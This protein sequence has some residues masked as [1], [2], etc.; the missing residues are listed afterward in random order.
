MIKI[1]AQRPRRQFPK[2]FQNKKG[3]ALLMAIVLTSTLLLITYALSNITLKAL[4]LSYAGKNSE[5]AFYAADTGVECAQYWDI[6]NGE[7]NQGA[8]YTTPNTTIICNGN[9][10]V[11]NGTTRSEVNTVPEP[12][13]ASFGTQTTPAP[14][15]IVSLFQFCVN[16]PCTT[17]ANKFGPCAI[18]TVTK[19]TNPSTG[20]ITTSIE[21]R[22]YN[23]CNTDSVQRFE[24][25]LYVTY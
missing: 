23:T 4:N 19:V 14:A 25:A 17:P 3:F 20:I 12:S 1:S 8:F 16:G 21:S 9:S 11:G 15:T 6:R 2:P 24:R 5:L 22:G 10:I 18:V 13:S 7:A